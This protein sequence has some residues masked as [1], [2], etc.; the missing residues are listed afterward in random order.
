[1]WLVRPPSSQSGRNEWCGLWQ[2]TA[3]VLQGA[4][5]QGEWTG[6]LDGGDPAGYP[7]TPLL[8]CQHPTG[9]LSRMVW[10][11]VRAQLEQ[12]LESPLP[13][14]L[15]WAWAGVQLTPPLTPPPAGGVGRTPDQTRPQGEEGPLR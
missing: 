4:E 2:V 15:L 11:H 5:P 1:M 3:A 14:A 6:P 8:F 9:S 7:F 13:A 12:V 10:H